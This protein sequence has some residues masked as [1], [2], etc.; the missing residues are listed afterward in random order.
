MT[1]ITKAKARK[2]FNDGETITIVPHK[3]SPVKFE[4]FI[5]MNIQKDAVAYTIHEQNYNIQ[6]FDLW[7]D[8]YTAHTCN[9]KNG[10]YVAY[11]IED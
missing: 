5:S 3:V 11:Y 4:G 9:F 6:G 1:R 8:C 10:Y 2:M 7:V